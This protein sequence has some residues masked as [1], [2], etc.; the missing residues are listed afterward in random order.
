VT[1]I[2]Y[3]PIILG[4]AII[5]GVGFLRRDRLLIVAM[6]T[7][8]YVMVMLALLWSWDL[9]RDATFA[10]FLAAIGATLVTMGT[11]RSR[12]EKRDRSPASSESVGR[13]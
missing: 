6:T 11:E 4:A 7:V 12:H 1:L 9:G 8:G 5:G 13:T 10:I 3:W 2:D